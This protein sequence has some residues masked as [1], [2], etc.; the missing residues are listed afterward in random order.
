MKCRTGESRLLQAH[1]SL[2]IACASALFLSIAACGDGAMDID[3]TKVVNQNT[4]LKVDGTWYQKASDKQGFEVDRQVITVKF[5]DGVSAAEAGNLH[6]ALGGHVLRRAETGFV[7]VRIAD[8]ADVMEMVEIY[9]HSGLVAI[10][11]PTTR[12]RYLVTPN[13]PN[14]GMQWHLTQTRTDIAWHRETGSS[15]TVI[16]ILD[17]GTDFPHEDLG[18]GTDAY[19]N[20]WRNAG[21]DAWADPNDPTTGN[22]LDDD[23]NG[24]ADDWKGWDFHNGDND[25]RGPFYHG[26]HVAG[27]AAGKTHN[28]TGIAGVAGGWAGAGGQMMI[29]G[30]GDNFPNGAILDD[31]ILYAAQNGAD[32]IQLSLSVGVSAAIDAALQTAYM[33]YGV[34]IANASGNNSNPAVSYPASNPHVMAVGGTT[35]ADMRAGFANYGPNLEIAAPADDIHSSRI[36]DTYGTGDGTSYASPQ[37][38]GTAALMLAVNPALSNADIRSILH[39][40]ADKVGG[41]DYNWNIADPGHSQELGHGRLNVLRAVRQSGPDA[42]IRDRLN[43]TGL[44]PDPATAGQAMYQSPDI[45]VRHAPDGIQ[46]HQNPEFGQANYVYVRVE[47][48]GYLPANGS[49]ELYYA[50]AST[51]LSWPVDWTLIDTIPVAGLAPG[52]NQ[53]VNTT[54]NP[55]ATGHYCLIARWVAADDPMTFTETASIGYNTRYNNN[56]AWKNMTVVDLF[57]S[58]PDLEVITRVLVRNV[59]KRPDNIDLVFAVPEDEIR[60]PFLNYGTVIM[61]LSDNLRV[62]D[63]A[64]AKQIGK[65][66]FQITDLARARFYLAEMK[67]REKGELTFTFALNGRLEKPREFNFD[68]EQFQGNQGR[69]GGETYNIR[70]QK[71]KRQK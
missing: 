7:D 8:H 66:T 21:E 13:D 46:V 10:A 6:R 36:G 20:V 54:W 48:L 16:A 4:Y 3:S 31:A 14:Y 24:F 45:W 55:P 71:E 28:G 33:T 29:V 38:S 61:E 49:I 19:Q 63:F 43:D 23:L 65:R 22:G 58:L 35:A 70:V 34:F 26:T 59:F 56:I 1:T 52:A 67:G 17:S 44:E 32:V 50:Q 40:T 39:M 9:Q 41:Y 37:V 53:S 12:G 11:E 18:Q 27:I 42:W 15:A 69:V 25:G 62:R 64:G 5:R 30:V 60:D 2:P 47:N 57:L 68:V 51:G